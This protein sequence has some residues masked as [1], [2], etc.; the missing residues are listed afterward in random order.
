MKRMCMS[1]CL[2]IYVLVSIPIDT[3][4]QDKIIVKPFCA[5]NEDIDALH[6]RT[7]FVMDIKFKK[8]NDKEGK[9]N[10]KEKHVYDITC[11]P[12]SGECKA[13][14]LQLDPLENGILGTMYSP[15]VFSLKSS[16]NGVYEF[17]SG[18]FGH[19]TADLNIGEIT[20]RE[21][22]P[23][24]VGGEILSKGTIDKGPWITLKNK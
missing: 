18:I 13:I 24:L 1:L 14:I 12:S 5:V 4:A 23:D 6:I 15:D 20:Y 7:V 19:I 8:E 3:I 21:S 22:W 10:R 2:A 16:V 17:Q 11:K 9:V